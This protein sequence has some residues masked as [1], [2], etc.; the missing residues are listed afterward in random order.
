MVNDS[1]DCPSPPAFM[2]C[3]PGPNSLPCELNQISNA[4]SCRDTDAPPPNWEVLVCQIQNGESRAEEDLYRLINSG[5]R[6]TLL[7]HLPFDEVDDKVHDTF[8]I[9]LQAIR[10]GRLREPQRLLGFIWTVAHRQ[11]FA[12]IEFAVANRRRSVLLDSQP[13][14]LEIPLGANVEDEILLH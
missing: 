7:R 12:H 13:E 2:H 10:A 4:V 1:S 8:V 6:F 9:V 5:V 14:I 3:Q 11:V